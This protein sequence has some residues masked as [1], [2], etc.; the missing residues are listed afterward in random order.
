M[1]GEEKLRRYLDRAFYGIRQ[2]E[3]I[4][5]EKEALLAELIKKYRTLIEQGYDSESAY[6]SVISGIGDIFEL[7]DGIVRD[8]GLEEEGVP[9]GPPPFEERKEMPSVRKFSPTFYEAAPFVAAGFLLLFQLL[10]IYAPAGPK[11]RTFLPLLFLGAVIGAAA[12]W[13]LF[14]QPKPLH[15]KQNLAV[16]SIMAVVWCVAAVLF[17]RAITKPHLAKIMWLIP[18]GALAL[19]QLIAGMADYQE[20]KKRGELNE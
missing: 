14:R 19:N 1:K 6:Q 9:E 12:L 8:T 5:E 4:Q 7:V 16:Y 2:T 15:D 11:E 20:H 13:L 3:E 17:F 18:L 10:E